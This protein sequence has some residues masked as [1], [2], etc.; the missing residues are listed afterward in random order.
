MREL[1]A[2]DISLYNQLEDFHGQTSGLCSRVWEVPSLLSWVY[3]FAAYMAVLT[4]D[5]R[6][7][8]I[9]AYCSLIIRE[10]LRHG[11]D[12]WLEYDRTFQ[13]W[14]HLCLGIRLFLVCR[15]LPF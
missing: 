14:I 7:R 11:G 10:A 5:P 4:P 12:G 1:L 6:T 8:E 15:Q 2:D 3:C 13:R 9:L